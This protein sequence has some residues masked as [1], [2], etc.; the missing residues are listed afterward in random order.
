MDPYIL[1]ELFFKLKKKII[2]H[3]LFV[4]GEL[5]GIPV[6][7]TL[8]VKGQLYVEHWAPSLYEKQEIVVY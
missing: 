6:V 5:A 8:L 2:C 7:R 3:I 1:Y 4:E